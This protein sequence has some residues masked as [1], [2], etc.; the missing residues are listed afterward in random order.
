MAST[1]THVA[2]MGYIP[3][4][5]NASNISLEGQLSSAN[6]RPVSFKGPIR[7]KPERYELVE[8]FKHTPGL[9]ADLANATEATR[10]P[11]NRDFE[12]LG[13]NATSALVTF[14]TTT[15]GITL[16]TAGAINDQ[17]IILP[18]L[19]TNQTSWTGT[20]WGTENQ[21]LWECCLVTSATITNQ[22][23]W[24][25]LKLTNVPAIADDADQ[26]YFRYSTGDSNTT[27]RCISSVGGTDTNTDSGITVAASTQYRFTIQIDPSR[28]ARFYINEQLVHTTGA[29][30]NDVDLIPYVGIQAL[31]AAAAAVNLVY[32]KISRHP[33]E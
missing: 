11:R 27:W 16:T 12:T 10:V 8:Y 13:T 9:N 25:G 1:V 31:S 22:I 2:A 32:E 30:T 3:S 14:G 21:V 5:C 29:L 4:Y 28:V 24:A 20:L 17:I 7:W 33:F 6:D 19:D 15:A 23:L 26:V 18:H